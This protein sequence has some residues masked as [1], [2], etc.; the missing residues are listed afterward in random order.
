MV[1]V[2]FYFLT[3][4][5]PPFISSPFVIACETLFWWLCEILCQIR[6]IS[7]SFWCLLIVIQGEDFLVLNGMSICATFKSVLQARCDTSPWGQGDAASMLPHCCPPGC[8]GETQLL[9]YPPAPHIA[10]ACT[11]G[12]WSLAHV[13]CHLLKLCV[14][15]RLLQMMMMSVG[16]C[17]GMADISG[18][19]SSEGSSSLPSRLSEE[20]QNQ[21]W[22][23]SI[24]E[25]KKMARWC[26]EPRA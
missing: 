9:P 17:L 18:L 2:Y 3:D 13:L 24:H 15:L 6:S 21:P 26:P 4:N 12:H 11:E 10:S 23:G 1:L 20:G 7:E 14:M 8:G 5:F 22:S 16:L 19:C 25:P